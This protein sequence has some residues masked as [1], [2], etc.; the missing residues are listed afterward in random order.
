MTNASNNLYDHL[1]DAKREEFRTLLKGMTKLEQMD[2]CEWLGVYLGQDANTMTGAAD[3]RRCG[4]QMSQVI[5][6]AR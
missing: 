3:L 1:T 5:S 4:K 6:E 2:L